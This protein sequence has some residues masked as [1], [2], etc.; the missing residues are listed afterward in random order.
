MQRNCV[1]TEVITLKELNPHAGDIVRRMLMDRNGFYYPEPLVWQVLSVE[2]QGC[3]VALA[4]GQGH[5]PHKYLME[6]HTRVQA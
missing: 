4:A 3:V 5:T 1:M 2:E 6:W